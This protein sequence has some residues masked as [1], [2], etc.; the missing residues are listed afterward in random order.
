MSSP[1]YHRAL[2]RKIAAKRRCRGLSQPALATMI[3]RS[4]AWVSQ[5][6]RGV[7][8]AERIAGCSRR[9]RR[10]PSRHLAGTAGSVVRF[11]GPVFAVARER[12]Q[13]GYEL[14]PFFSA[15]A[16]QDARDSMG[17]HFRKL[18]QTA[19]RSGDESAAQ[20]CLRA[21]ERM[22]REVVDEMTV[23]GTRYR[24][25]RADRF[26]SSGPAG[27]EPPRPSD[28]GPGEP[29]QGHEVTDPAAGG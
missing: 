15:L 13:G 16:P 17:S 4:V 5:V 18:A 28:G 22:D 19:E 6:E 27:P 9:R 1:Y 24:V 21:A 2:G 26:I 12:E 8:K 3:D 14:H 25:L 10:S 29:G 7:P 11:G 23:L 20:E